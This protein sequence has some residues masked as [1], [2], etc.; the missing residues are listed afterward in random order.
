M[1]FC[2][3]CLCCQTCSLL[4]YSKRKEFYFL[5]WN[6]IF[7]WFIYEKTTSTTASS[8]TTCSWSW[9]QE[10]SSPTA[11]TSDKFSSRRK[12]LTRNEAVF[13]QLSSRGF[14]QMT[15]LR[16]P[17]TRSLS[18]THNQFHSLPSSCYSL[19]AA[20][21][22]AHHFSRSHKLHW[23]F[24]F[25]LP[26]CLYQSTLAQTLFLFCLIVYILL[27]FFFTLPL[28]V[29]KCGCQFTCCKISN[30]SRSPT[31]LLLRLLLL[32]C[33]R[34]L[35]VVVV[36]HLKVVVEIRRLREISRVFCYC[37]WL[38]AE[39]PPP[40]CTTCLSR[41]SLLE[42]FDHRGSTH[43]TLLWRVRIL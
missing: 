36:T 15:K 4:F 35:I 40:C 2:L 41:N 9:V 23:M 34:T 16:V 42:T 17:F 29:E 39:S 24:L 21:A 38:I 25:F 33:P 14:T 27:G 10:F 5:A 43:G 8:S 19:T 32:K 31:D 1:W 20:V 26:S 13:L 12:K 22:A 18:L 6:G 11:L 30:L 7:L 37:C 28:A 3:L